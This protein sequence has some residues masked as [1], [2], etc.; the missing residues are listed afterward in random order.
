MCLAGHGNT[1]LPNSRPAASTALPLPPL[2]PISPLAP[3]VVSFLPPFF[4]SS[5]RGISELFPHEKTFPRAKTAITAASSR[6]PVLDTLAPLVPP[7]TVAVPRSFAVRGTNRRIAAPPS[8]TEQRDRFQTA[9]EKSVRNKK[10]PILP[11]SFC[12]RI[13]NSSTP[14]LPPTA[15]DADWL[16]ERFSEPVSRLRRHALNCR[17]SVRAP[18]R[19]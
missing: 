1:L 19:L 2:L 5:L 8:P 18:V 9:T 12:A 11:S 4:L 7:E 3:I 13:Q 16:S 17:P 14:L 6:P 15:T 10:E